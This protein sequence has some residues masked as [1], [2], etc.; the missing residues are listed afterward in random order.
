MAPLLLNLKFLESTQKKQMTLISRLHKFPLWVR[1]IASPEV[2]CTQ[3]NFCFFLSKYHMFSEHSCSSFGLMIKPISCRPKLSAQL[4][5]TPLLLNTQFS[6]IYDKLHL[7]P[8]MSKQTT[9]LPVHRRI[10]P[11]TDTPD[12]ECSEQQIYEISNTVWCLSAVQNQY[13]PCA[14]RTFWINLTGYNCVYSNHLKI[15]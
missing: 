3:R 2:F 7:L 6:S 4:R 12:I 8:W 13:N 11:R 10:L 5:Y 1:V 14:F 15:T 9:V